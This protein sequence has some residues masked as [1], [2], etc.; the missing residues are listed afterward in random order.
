MILEEENANFS[1]KNANSKCLCKKEKLQDI[2]CRNK[3]KHDTWNMYVNLEK[4]LTN[5]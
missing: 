1:I 5:T 4:I 3:L 2:L